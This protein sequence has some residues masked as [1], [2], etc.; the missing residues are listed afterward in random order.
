ML[1]SNG[2]TVIGPTLKDGV[3]VYD[4]QT[5]SDSLPA[6]WTSD[7]A[8]G[9]YVAKRRNDDALFG[10]VHGSNSW[11]SF[12]HPS[13]QKLWTAV[14]TEQGVDLS[15]PEEETDKYAFIG[16]RACELNA[17]L[18]QDKV[19]ESSGEDDTPYERRRR[20]AFI[21]AVNCTEAG[22]TCFCTSMNTGPKAQTGY[23]IAL[24]ELVSDQQHLFVAEAGTPLGE[25]VLSQVPL[26]DAASEELH[27]ADRAIANAI[28]TMGRDMETEGIKDLLQANPDHPRWDEVA[29]RCL[30]C[31]N[32]T[33][34]CPTCF[35]T[36]ITDTS[37]LKGQVAERW[38]SWDSCFTMDFTYLGG[39]PIRESRRSRYR[40]WMTHK[41][42]SWYDQFDTSGCVG[43]G[44]CITWCP[45]GIDLT[46]EV[47]AIRKTPG[48]TQERDP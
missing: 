20:D 21:I 36:T 15:V 32:C 18:V 35:C 9:R 17:I 23:D 39:G 14:K 8:P 45:V 24:T 25:D 42:A 16:V 19:F 13:K 37:D 27:Q 7:Q 29:D 41:L 47:K 40:H 38:Q 11:K 33:M 31:A 1:A 3:I 46:E 48:E 22:G 28:E 30:A 43:C 4:E 44:R 34:V 26:R 2:Y 5:S 10:Y 12:L 6:G